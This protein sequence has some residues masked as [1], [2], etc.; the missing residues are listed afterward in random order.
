MDGASSHRPPGAGSAGPAWDHPTKPAQK[1][2]QTWA[3]E[4]T[5]AL[6]A[7]DKGKLDEQ[8]PKVQSAFAKLTGWNSTPTSSVGK[9]N[10]T[11]EALKGILRRE[12]D[13]A[14]AYV[15]EGVRH[16]FLREVNAT[17]D[18]IFDEA[19][20]V[21]TRA[22]GADKVSRVTFQRAV[23]AAN[24]NVQD[25]LIDFERKALA[26]GPK[27]GAAAQAPQ[28]FRKPGTNSV[29]VVRKAPTLENLVLRGGGAKGLAYGPALVEMEKQGLLGGLKHVVGTSAGALTATCLAAGFSATEFA[30]FSKKLEPDAMTKTI[31]NF[32]GRYPSVTLSGAAQYSGQGAL[33]TLDHASAKSVAAYLTDNWN[34]EVFQSRLVA[35]MLTPEQVARLASLRN[36]DL[37]PQADR[38]DQMITFGDV[39]L[40]HQL[41]PAKFRE[42]TVT[43]L[44][45]GPEQLVYFDADQTPDMPIAIAGRISMALPGWFKSVEYDPKDGQ[46][47]RV[48]LFTSLRQK[49]GLEEPSTRRRFKDGGLANNL[50]S[51]VIT[52]GKGG[53]QL[54]E[55]RARTAVLV[56]DE[57]GKAH[58]QIY[59]SRLSPPVKA[60]KAFKK[61]VMGFGK[62]LYKRWHN[63]DAAQA[64]RNDKRKPWE[65]GVNAFVVYHG[66]IK[67]E[68]VEAK[69]ARVGFAT[70]DSEFRM[71]QQLRQRDD[72]LYAV[73]YTD[74]RH[75]FDALSQD[76]RISLVNQ[77]EPVPAGKETELYRFERAVYDMAVESLRP[78]ALQPDLANAQPANF[79]QANQLDANR[80]PN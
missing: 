41:D 32:G 19:L 13:G 5:Q 51:E 64:S 24:H 45:A 67:T 21:G 37:G 60:L 58:D 14:A 79:R 28:F 18:L 4:L 25:A 76:E 57:A 44:D 48:G 66:D 8:P 22:P 10:E 1:Q 56:F 46:L 16:A 2:A 69:A 31:E 27:P 20:A 36:P 43:G 38:T 26:S 52:G 63:S 59:S 30:A 9:L 23:V 7:A 33:E 61:G 68:D 70:R 47:P 54:E 29:Q 53:R 40:L 78:P 42:L 15:D 50:P 39:R 12:V 35:L 77:G 73:E 74:P 71:L 17:I 80:P 6:K 75:C 49:L 11:R 72:Q 65:A 55:A 34:S 3:A 62:D